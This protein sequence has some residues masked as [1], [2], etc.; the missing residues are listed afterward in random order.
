MTEHEK[1]D[2]PKILATII[3]SSPGLVIGTGFAYL[4]L[5][6]DLHRSARV[7]Y[8]GMI[9]AGMPVEEAQRL[10]EKYEN[11]LSTHGLV[12]SLGNS[13]PGGSLFNS[14]K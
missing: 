11:D 10:K 4:R 13:F 3:W 2:V 1:Q 9:D 8:R 7:F 5:R 6:R 12:K 14:G